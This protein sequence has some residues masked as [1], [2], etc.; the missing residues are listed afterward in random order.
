MMN[1]IYIVYIHIYINQKNKRMYPLFCFIQM[2]LK[3]GKDPVWSVKQGTRL[4]YQVTGS[5]RFLSVCF[6]KSC[7]FI[8]SSCEA[9]SMSPPGA[10]AFCLM[11]CLICSNNS[12]SS[13]ALDLLLS[14]P[15]LLLFSLPFLSSFYVQCF[16]DSLDYIQDMPFQCTLDVVYVFQSLWFYLKVGKYKEKKNNKTKHGSSS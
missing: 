15:F 4:R 2:W 10:D 7:M 8:S 12:S 3:V 9:E 13:T 11:I 5:V 16:S 1:Y 6:W 14:M